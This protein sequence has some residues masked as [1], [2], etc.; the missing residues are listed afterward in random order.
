MPLPGLPLALPQAVL[1]RIAGDL[2]ALARIARTAPRQLDRLLDLGEQL[3]AIGHEAVLIGERIDARAEQILTLGERIDA[4]AQQ[5]LAVGERLDLRGTALVELGEELRAAGE[6]IDA[7][8]AEIVDRAAHVA[9]T[10]SE[11]VNVIP[12]LERAIQMTTPLEGAIDRFGRLVDRLP[13]GAARR[14]ADQ[15]ASGVTPTRD[16][17]RDPPAPPAER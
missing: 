9:R 14:R 4:R 5:I 2:N 3:V 16:P 6:Q 12:T 13:G 7:R 1:N 10:G 11:L 8:G 17:S 15:T